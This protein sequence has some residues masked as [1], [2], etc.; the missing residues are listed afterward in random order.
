[1]RSHLTLLMLLIPV[2]VQSAEREFVIGELQ[3]EET[4]EE[5]IEPQPEPWVHLPGEDIIFGKY[6]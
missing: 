2:L 5:Q 4:I 6:L 1:M 3:N